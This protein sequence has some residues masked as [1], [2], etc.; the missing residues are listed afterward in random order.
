MARLSGGSCDYDH[1]FLL[2]SLKFSIQIKFGCCAISESVW[3]GSVHG[4][5]VTRKQ[6]G[7]FNR[8]VVMKL[9][10]ASADQ[11]EKSA[12]S[13]L[14]IHD[15]PLDSQRASLAADRKKCLAE[16]VDRVVIEFDS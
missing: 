13:D 8:A 10:P 5:L 2:C 1:L 3:P 4:R 14:Q 16:I 7:I 6:L 11:L 9:P 12:G 15:V